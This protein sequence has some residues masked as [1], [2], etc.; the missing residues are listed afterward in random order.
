MKYNSAYILCYGI[1]K[2]SIM[3][4]AVGPVNAVFTLRA[5]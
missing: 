3:G 2:S 1:K 5:I 4:G